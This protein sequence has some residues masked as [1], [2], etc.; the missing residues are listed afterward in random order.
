MISIMLQDAVG[1]AINPLVRRLAVAQ[2]RGLVSPARFNLII[3]T[4]LVRRL[5]RG[6]GG[7]IGMKA[8][9]VQPVAFRNADDP[10]PRSDVRGRMPGF[11]EDAA[12]KRSANERLAA[13][14]DELRALRGNF[15]QPKGRLFAVA[16]V[17]GGGQFIKVGI[18]FVP[19]PRVR[20]KVR[21][22]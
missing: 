13:I 7:T 16:T 5:K 15:P 1:F 2:G 21:G 12:F 6:F 20:A 4:Q 17:V 14:N 18:K 10:F 8:N 22:D 19:Q 9:Q 11:G 3:K